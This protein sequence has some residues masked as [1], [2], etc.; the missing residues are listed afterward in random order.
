MPQNFELRIPNSGMNRDDDARLIENSESRFILNLRSGSSEDDNVGSLENIKGTTEIKFDL[1]SGTNVC[2]GSYGDQTTH[3][4]F[5]F[6]YN[7]LG[8]HSI[9]RYLPETRSV[10]LLVQDPILAFQEESLINDI[11]VI[12]NLLYWND[13]VIPPR[14]INIDK[15]DSDREDFRQCFNFYLGDNYVN[16]DNPSNLSKGIEI[17]IRDKRYSPI[18]FTGIVQ[19]NIDDSLLDEK[20]ELAKDV[21]AQFNAIN[22]LNGTPLFWEAEACGEFVKITILSPQFYSLYSLDSTGDKTSQIIPQNHYQQYIERTIDV[23]K[24]PPQCNPTATIET[25]DSFERNFVKDKVFQFAA[26]YIYDDNEKTVVSP[27]S[28]NIYNKYTCA[29]FVDDDISNYI[30]INLSVYPEL[31]RYEDLQT[32]KR[33]ELFVKEGQLGDWRS[34]TTLEQY[35]FVDVVE[36]H[37]DFYNNFVYNP[38]DQTTFVRPYHTV[39][40]LSKTQESVKNR[41]FYGNNLEQ[42]DPTCI[43]AN[44]DVQYDDVESRIKAPTHNVKGIILI[45]AAFNGKLPDDD[46]QTRSPAKNQPIRK[47]GNPGNFGGGS[48][49]GTAD[50]LTVWGGISEGAGNDPEVFDMAEKTGQ[51]LPLDGF[52]VYL[53]GTDFYDIS[54]QNRGKTHSNVN[55]NAKG[56]YQNTGSSDMNQLVNKIREN[57]REDNGFGLDLVYWRE[58]SDYSFADGGANDP[59]Q[60]FSTFNIQNVP[61]GWYILRVASHKTTDEDLK[62]VN[63]GYQGTSTNVVRIQNLDAVE[64]PASVNYIK[65]AI[66]GVN[67]I[68]INVRGGNVPRLKIEITDI[69]HASDFG[70]SKICTG[71]MVDNDISNPINTYDGFLEDTR[72]ARAFIG[73]DEAPSG[74][75]A[76]AGNDDGV[77]TRMARWKN[78]GGDWGAFTDHNGYFWYASIKSEA[79]LSLKS[80]KNGGTPSENYWNNGIKEK[81]GRGSTDILQ[82]SFREVAIKAIPGSSFNVRTLVKGEVIDSLGLGVPKASVVSIRGEVA[83]CDSSGVYQ[84]FHYSIIETQAGNPSLDTYLIPTRISGACSP[85]YN[86]NQI[87]N[88][89]FDFG[90]LFSDGFV[91][92]P[93]NR[94]PSAGQPPAILK[95]QIPTFLADISN[96]ATLNSMKRGWDGKFGIVYYDRGLRSSAVNSDETLN[97]HIPFYTELD[98][99]GLQKIGIPIMN[100]EIKHTPPQWATHWQWVRTRNE[101]VGSYFQW[102]LKTIEYQD[103]NGNNASYNNATRVKV[104][105]DNL[106]QYKAINPTMN[107]EATPD[108]ETWRIRFIKDSSQNY[109]NLPTGLE[110]NDYKILEFSESEN[111]IVFEKDF[112]LPQISPGTLVEIYNEKLDLEEEIFFEFAECFEVGT[113]I[114]GNKFHKGLDQDQDPL[115]PENIPATGVLRTGDAYYRLRTIPEV[116]SNTPAYIDDD[117]VSDFYL[118]EVESIGRANG[119]NPDFFQKWK[120]NQIRHGGKYIPDS[121][122]NDLSV[123]VAA[124]FQPLPISYGDIYK[125]QLASNVLLSIHAFRWVS[126]YIEEGIIRK[127]TGDNE[128][129]ASTKVFDSFRAAKPITGTINPESVKEFRGRVYAVDINKGLVN[130]YDANGLTAISAYKMVDFFSDFSK[131]ILN[132]TNS[133][134]KKP[135]ILGFIDHKRD[136]Y[137]ISVNDL[138]PTPISNAP[139]TA[140][141]VNTSVDINRSFKVKSAGNETLFSSN[142]LADIN[143]IIFDRTLT[144]N[145]TNIQVDNKVDSLGILHVKVKDLEGQINTVSTLEPGQGIYDFNIN[146][147]TFIPK[148]RTQDN[149]AS[150]SKRTEEELVYKGFTVAYNNRFNK[151]TTFYSFRPE[152][153]G[154]VDLEMLGFTNGKLW[155]HND[156]EIRNNFYGV[157]YTSIL[158]TIFN[159][160]PSQVKVFEAVG[161]DSYYA[162]KVPSAK[163]KN[164]MET[165]IVAERFVRREDSFYA[166]VMRDKNDP[167]RPSPQDAIINGRQLR[168]RTIRVTF[169]NEDTD[170]VVLFSVSMLSTISTRHGK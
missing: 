107:L 10:R 136:E 11:N 55:Q 59:T 151:W 138:F 77:N 71:Y 80:A 104:F 37:F 78:Q 53:A 167:S 40:I 30:K 67:E 3:S 142:S 89:D 99:D 6:I 166:P 87:Y 140:A 133:T 164:G 145:L 32:I 38:V 63:R 161:A 101:T 27:Y 118:S 103:F 36:T 42:Y 148:L 1:P 95:L 22:S 122:V 84:F 116:S 109:F 39:P 44:I 65:S 73:F 45:R 159:N 117:A 81:N 91:P 17:E 48:S 66:E 57:M 14:K 139:S 15:A 18:T 152:M 83:K 162:W 70:S 69:S 137:I 28:P 155:I 119:I 141:R 93:P 56:V 169:E 120:P 147:N 114:N 134:T 79:A 12:D 46:S 50:A 54:N 62:D 128:I 68:L 124:N 26:R 35:Q 158:E 150:V 20:K 102:A 144:P 21:A 113:D 108:N 58:Q 51:T 8:N 52:T 163:T 98:S 156:S 61:D 126:N 165:E 132:I 130:Q 72:I 33:I 75:T 92:S 64:N 170:E 112:E 23:I 25:N 47:D 154:N 13:G 153:F 157:Q 9:F 106:V 74:D 143:N 129:V 121:N 115:D 82:D 43:D 135:R 125:L 131:T 29:Q 60:V 88:F 127:Q 2:I 123:F 149:L 110:Y 168:D 86:E 90:S 111:S 19:I 105:I 96:L 34:I 97:I 49:G 160:L 76:S 41:I 5:F 146:T 85:F 31:F 7:S 94:I 16:N 4:N 24:H 100:W